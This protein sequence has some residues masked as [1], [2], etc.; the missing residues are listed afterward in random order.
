MR[1]LRMLVV[2]GLHASMACGLR[3]GVGT[4]VRPPLHESLRAAATD[5]ACAASANGV[6]DPLLAS[7]A[8]RAGR[9]LVLARSARAAACRAHTREGA[10]CAQMQKQD[11]TGVGRRQM[12]SV[13]AAAAA[14]VL[15]RGPAAAAPPGQDVQPAEE[16]AKAAELAWRKFVGKDG[17]AAWLGFREAEGTYPLRFIE[18][19]ARFLLNFDEGSRELFVSQAEE[20]S[21]L[22]RNKRQEAR[23]EQFARFSTS[24]EYGLRRYSGADGA[25]KLAKVLVARYGRDNRDALQQIGFLFAL[26]EENQPVQEISRVLARLENATVDSIVI[27]DGG[28]GYTGDVPQV[29]IEDPNVP[30]GPQVKA[31]AVCTLR[32][33]GQLLTV[34]IKNPGLGYLKPPQVLFTGLFPNASRATLSQLN[35]ASVDAR[36][37]IQVLR[38]AAPIPATDTASVRILVSM[39]P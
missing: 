27:K 17:K 39:C 3:V 18:Y 20:L 12:V 24:V 15:L 13:S 36:Q 14:A 21:V 11:Q 5:R 4:A 22:P 26:M 6:C 31:E 35:N 37:L 2:L 38:A 7:P 28:S 1:Q 30:H 10:L 32:E 8:S 34:R 33:T 9:R 29:L 23:F 25:V 19:L 16:A